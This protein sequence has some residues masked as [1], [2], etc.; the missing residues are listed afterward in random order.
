MSSERTE[1]RVDLHDA[2]DLTRAIG[3]LNRSTAWELIQQIPMRFSTFHP[4][5]LA[6]V[7]AMTFMSSVELWQSPRR[8]TPAGTRYDRTPGRGVGHVFVMDDDG[9]LLRDITLSVGDVYHPGG[10]DFDGASVWVPLAQYRPEGDSIVYSIDP[11]TMGVEER[12]RVDDHVGW[13]AS[14]GPD[15]PVHGGSWGSRTLYTWTPEGKLLDRWQ[16]PSHFVDF[17]DCQHL[18]G[19]SL[20]CSGVAELPQPSGDGT[21]ELGGLAIICP[22]ERRVLHETPVPCFSEAGHAVT[23]NPVAMTMTSDTLTL[24]AAPDDGREGTALLRYDT[25]I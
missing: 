19:G 9:S 17:Q 22:A 12:F 4:Q 6:F 3:A 15:G 24:W 23:R 11:T 18:S 16:N 7:D 13:V 5:G 14:A 25:R 1:S 10:I 8:L 20:L 2:N 21:Y